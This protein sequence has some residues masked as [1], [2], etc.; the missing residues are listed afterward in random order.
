MR[1]RARRNPLLAYVLVGGLSYAV[2]AGLL[3]A[4]SSGLGVAVWVAA[5]VGYWTSV[6]V[7]FGLNRLLF[8]TGA[9][10]VH[11][12]AVRYGALLAVNYLVTLGVL[13]LG[14]QL[15]VPL[16]VTKTFAV[17]LTTCWNFVLY[18]VWVF[19]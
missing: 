18:R 5:T 7:N 13:H 6:V 15:G 11:R 12:H 16:L 19:R 10:G 9:G 3:L 2:D 8:H 14:E 1:D 4:L 17:G